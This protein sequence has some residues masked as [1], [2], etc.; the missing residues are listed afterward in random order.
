MQRLL[1]KHLKLYL[2]MFIFHPPLIFPTTS[3]ELGQKKRPVWIT[4]G[5]APL[6]WINEWD[7]IVTLAGAK[8]DWGL[9]YRSNVMSALN[10]LDR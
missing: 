10:R 8:A 7:R 9:R 1:K 4:P 3:T 5:A 2:N 6:R